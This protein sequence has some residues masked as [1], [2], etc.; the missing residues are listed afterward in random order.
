M[1]RVNPNDPG[2]KRI[3]AEIPDG[4]MVWID[5]THPIPERRGGK[6][7]RKNRKLSNWQAGL[8]RD[9][10]N[11]G[12]TPKELAYEFGVSS[13]TIFRIIRREGTY[14]DDH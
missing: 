7:A 1:I 14:K 12:R 5:R 11:L 2:I 10:Y 6:G 4:T 13:R 3:L 8:V 9:D